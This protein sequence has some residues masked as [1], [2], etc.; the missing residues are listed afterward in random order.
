MQNIQRKLLSNTLP[1]IYLNFCFFY[2]VQNILHYGKVDPSGFHISQSPQS[3]YL[4]IWTYCS[5]A[6]GLTFISTSYIDLLKENKHCFIFQGEGL[7]LVLVNFRAPSTVSLG[8]T[9]TPSLKKSR[10]NGVKV[11]NLFK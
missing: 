4:N 10:E 2:A 1:K 11:C 9:G 6:V 5:I 7:Y 3:I 8:L